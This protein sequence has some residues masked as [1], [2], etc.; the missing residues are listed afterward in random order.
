MTPAERIE[1]MLTRNPYNTPSKDDAGVI[2]PRGFDDA[3]RSKAREDAIREC[4]RELN[5]NDLS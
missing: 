3:I 2:V 4:V 1:A 5:K